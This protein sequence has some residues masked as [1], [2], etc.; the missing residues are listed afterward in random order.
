MDK[1]TGMS[2]TERP[3]VLFV[4]QVFQE[5]PSGTLECNVSLDR[6]DSLELRS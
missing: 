3:N 1:K 4:R 2:S 5:K 6:R